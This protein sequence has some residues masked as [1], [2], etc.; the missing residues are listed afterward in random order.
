MMTIAQLEVAP[1]YCGPPDSGNGGYVAGLL[2]GFGCGP[3]DVRLRAP[4]PLG[5]VLEV[6]AEGEGFGLSD[7]GT[8]IATAL[9]AVV[10]FAVP[11]A[12]PFAAAHAAA[13]GFK[14]LRNHAA[15]RCFVCGTARAAGDGLRIFAGALPQPA[16]AQVAAPWVPDSALAG[17]RGRVRPEFLWAA[18][19][20]PGYYAVT[21]DA[22][23]MLLGRF[24]CRI[25]GEIAVGEACVVAGW[26]VGGVGRR[27]QAA[28]V[29]YGG[30][31]AVRARALATWVEL[32]AAA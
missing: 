24:A 30:D 10:D 11:P 32:K 3:M 25:D 22:R 15:P 4:V 18:L 21:P 8:R 12:V 14:G 17:T 19:D 31:G 20:C 28:T 2:A 27:H 1:R 6:E 5:R 7:R 26:R 23:M 29:L 9:P 16:L 13:T